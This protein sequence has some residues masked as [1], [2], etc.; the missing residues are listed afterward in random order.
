MPISGI[1]EEVVDKLLLSEIS[2]NWIRQSAGPLIQTSEKACFRKSRLNIRPYPVGRM[3][4]PFENLSK[5]PGFTKSGAC[6][7]IS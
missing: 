7:R 6:V 2:K 4:F 1:K 5:V 3:R